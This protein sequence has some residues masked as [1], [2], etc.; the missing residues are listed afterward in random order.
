M[1]RTIHGKRTKGGSTAKLTNNCCIFGIMGGTAPLTG[2]PLAHRAYLEKRA[3]RKALCITDCAQGHQYLKDNQILG[4]NP[5]AGGVGNMWR[6]RHYSHRSGPT[7]EGDGSAHGSRGNLGE[8]L[9][10]ESACSCT[11]CMS[12]TSGPCKTLTGICTGYVTPGNCPEGMT[13]C[14]VELS[15]Y[16][17]NLSG[18]LNNP[19]CD[20]DNNCISKVN[21]WIAGLKYTKSEPIPKIK[22]IIP[23]STLDNVHNTSTNP[24]KDAHG[25]WP[26]INFISQYGISQIFQ[27]VL[28]KNS[29]FSIPKF[30][31]DS[32]GINI[33]TYPN[34][35]WVYDNT[36]SKMYKS[37]LW[38]TAYPSSNDMGYFHNYKNINS[39]I[40]D[41][42]E[43]V[44]LRVYY[45]NTEQDKWDYVDSTDIDSYKEKVSNESVF[46]NSQYVVS[47]NGFFKY[48]VV[49]SANANYGQISNV[50]IAVPSDLNAEV[51]LEMYNNNTSFTMISTVTVNSNKVSSILEIDSIYNA[52]DDFQSAL[53]V[54][55]LSENNCLIKNMENFPVVF[56]AQTT[57]CNNLENCA[58][59][60][61][62]SWNGQEIQFSN[63][64]NPN[65]ISQIDDNNT[66][67]AK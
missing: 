43:P 13:D 49:S 37:S 47:G 38:H 14:C 63:N 35:L 6:H 52:T 58:N 3:S 31:T 41:D 42:K 65:D 61:I 32:S 19:G 62:Q 60:I 25:I 40:S 45:Y 29:N 26:G 50:I 54:E 21:G 46:V 4:C 36:K 33:L 17:I 44:T 2:K 66:I 57:D 28:W 48:N 67:D 9:G 5:Q 8:N 53:R 27:P 23:S 20:S 7:P 10:S 11:D 30:D 55:K 59:N 24:T 18:W 34:Y 51:S 39:W 15:K 16:T 64:F 22:L 56:E 1:G 12:G